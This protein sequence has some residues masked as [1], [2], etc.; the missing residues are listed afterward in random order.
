[1]KKTL[2]SSVI[3]MALVLS[4][5]TPILAAVPVFTDVPADHKYKAAIDYC[6]ENEFIV[7]KGGGK[8]DPDGTITRVEFITVW[9]KTFHARRHDFNDAT[10]TKDDM[11][12]AIVLMQGLGYVSGVSPKEFHRTG[13]ITREEVAQ[14]AYNTYLK[15]IDSKKEFEN[16]TDHAQVSK[17]A[18]HAISVCYKKG[19]FEKV[20]ENN[21]F[22]PKQHMTRAEVCAILMKLL[23]TEVETTRYTITIANM[24]FGTVEADKT[25][26]VE[27]ETVTLT[28]KSDTG[29]KYVDG[30][31]KY[32][33][34]AVTG[35]EF[36]MPADN[37]TITAEFE[38]EGENGNGNGNGNEPGNGGE[39]GNEPGNGNENGNEPGNG[40]NEP[41]NGNGGEPDNGSEPGTGGEN[42]QGEDE[43]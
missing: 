5:V 22:K 43:P 42:G 8:F 27:G 20:V 9:A 34:V 18:E 38:A 11:D 31:L 13:R 40:G 16:Y 15:G 2:L 7:G 4:M 39:N 36:K 3:A 28:V 29:Y 23:K 32:N 6:A 12:N 1:M 35:N 21:Q 26:A 41:G 14:I 19:I 37:V 33:G 30:S 17:W 24:E 10:K 25:E